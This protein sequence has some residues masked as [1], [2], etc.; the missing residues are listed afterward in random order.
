LKQ[1]GNPAAIVMLY[2]GVPEPDG[3]RLIAR[4]DGSVRTVSA[5]E[6]EKLVLVQRLPRK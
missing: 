1:V 3:G 5:E 2:S 4:A 6:W